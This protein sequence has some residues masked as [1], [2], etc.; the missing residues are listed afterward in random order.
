MIP[1]F[2]KI[3]KKMADDNKPVKYLR[4]AIGE[5]SL[6]VI[7]I[8]IALQ[9]N[10]WNQNRLE[11]NQETKLLKTLLKDLYIAETE[12][13]ELINKDQISFD[14][15]EFFLSGKNARET[16]INHP[17]IDSI[18]NPLI[19]GS[20]NTDIPVI[21]SYTDLKNA[22][23]TGLISNE[24][25]RIH[26]TAL[27]NRL[28]RL[29]KI[30]QDRLSVQLINIDKFVITEINFIQLLKQDKDTYTVDYGVEN[31]YSALFKNQF[32]LNAIGVKLELTESVLRDRERLLN[33]IKV[34]I[35]LIETEL[36]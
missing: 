29:D 23:Q 30:L 25:I 16:L 20:V 13:S 22:G 14:S 28:N 5:I 10:N 33:E 21:N 8:L 6:V 15:F 2:R 36:N 24:N 32:V 12:S 19:W 3:R 35:N 31:D 17:K 18:F 7:G 11:Q 34:L 26:F 1:I 9:I 27:E 4:Y